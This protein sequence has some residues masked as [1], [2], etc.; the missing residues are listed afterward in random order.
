[1]TPSRGQCARFRCARGYGVRAADTHCFQCNPGL[2]F[3][4][5]A[6]A[7]KDW[8]GE[9][10]VPESKCTKCNPELITK[11]VQAGDYCREHG[12]PQSVCPICQG[13]TSF[14]PEGMKV[15]LASAGTASDAGITTLRV[16]RRAFGTSLDVVGEL[17]FDPNRTAD[18]AALD[19]AVVRSVHV[20]VGDRVAKGDPLVT[21]A[22]ARI[23]GER[24][25]LAAARSRVETARARF[26][27]EERLLAK[28]VSSKADV[29]HA[30]R[31]LAEA[32]AAFT[33]ARSSL[34]AAGAGAGRGGTYVLRAPFD[35]TVALREA[36][37]G[38][39]VSA[40]EVLVRVADV[41][42]LWALLEIPG[43]SANAVRAG[44]AVSIRA[45]G[46]SGEPVNG[47]IAAIAPTIDPHTRTVRARVVLNNEGG[48]LKAGA[49]VRAS[50]S[51]GGARTALVVPRAAVQNGEGNRIVFIQEEP[52]V[53]RPVAV[54]LGES[55]GGEVE[56][57]AGL[58]EGDE[59]V[60]TGA[61]LLAT[62][63][64]KDSIGAG[65]CEVE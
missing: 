15:R 56:V 51:I 18:L 36:V 21:L 12:F 54:E 63:T 57:L 5:K 27:R 23:G 65:C 28:G 45:E 3:A 9:H 62:E 40:G 33:A 31:E 59:I 37:A 50:I 20:D 16:E 7:P 2:S 52:G 49:F 13:K 43:Q 10:G 60:G 1:M 32:R 34:D 35:G 42:S 29:E 46:A 55:V 25:S 38:R 47:T 24:A 26:E 48:V 44:Q 58:K 30:H 22:S 11:F 6:E 14:P 41:E 8:C 4:E 53:Y 64:R 61:F 19:D 39:G 17:A